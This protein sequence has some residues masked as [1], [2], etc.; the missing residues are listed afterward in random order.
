[1]FS[2]LNAIRMQKVLFGKSDI[3]FVKISKSFEKY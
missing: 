3:N 2:V 1:M